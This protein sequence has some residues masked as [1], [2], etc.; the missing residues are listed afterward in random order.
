MLPETG[1]SM[2]W[3]GP[4]TPRNPIYTDKQHKANRKYWQAQ[5]LPCARCGHW[6]DYDGPQYLLVNGRR[7]Q[8]PRY[9]VVGHKVSVRRATAAGWTVEQINALSN[10]QPECASCSNSS[11]AREGQQAQRAKQRRRRVLNTSRQ[12]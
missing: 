9:L 8:N 12:W 10:S 6:I 4:R 1:V 5:R 2:T 7:K 11:G 3:R